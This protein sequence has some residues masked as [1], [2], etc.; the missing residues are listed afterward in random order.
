MSA[1]QQQINS[2]VDKLTRMLQHLG[3]AAEISSVA[4]ER[5]IVLNL[6]TDDPGRVIGR[7]GKYLDSLELLVNSMMRKEDN[8]VP[9]IVIEVEGYERQ[10][11]EDDRRGGDRREGGRRGGSGLDILEKQALDAAKEVKRWGQPK[12]LGPFNSAERRAVHL[13]L[14]DD[15]SLETESLAEETD[16][17]KKIIIRARQK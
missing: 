5:R 14:R 8:D 3:F 1:T 16:G 10:K 7:K 17:R 9:R 4:D 12:T 13:A 2:S 6:K 11:F 15:A